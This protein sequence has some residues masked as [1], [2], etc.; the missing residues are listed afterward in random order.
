MSHTDSPNATPRFVSLARIWDRS[1]H[2]AFT[3]LLRHDAKWWCTFCE[4]DNHGSSIGTVRII[5][6]DDGESWTSIAEL[7]EADIDLRDPK[8]SVTPDGRMVLLTCGCTRGEATTRS[9][10]V[11]F[12][13]DGRNW[14]TP[15][16]VLT[17]D[18][19]LWR[20]T[21]HGK[22]GY[23]VPKLGEG[24][25]PRRGFLYRTTKGI[26]WQWITE[27]IFP[28]NIWTVSV[29]MLRIMPDEQMIALIRPNLIGSSDPPYTKWTFTPL[30]HL[31]GG[32][33]F[34]RLPD[35]ALW[36]MS[37]GKDSHGRPRTVLA[38]MSRNSYESV[39]EL[40]SGGDS[41]Y[42]GMVWHDETLWISITCHTKIRTSIYLAK[43]KF[44]A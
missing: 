34:I 6:S 35:D 36:A 14:S 25:N 32:P 15:A 10:W 24:R 11:A 28:G 19:W 7:T 30:D 41:S 4:A 27:F 8:L 31:L 16:R 3:D 37:R 40:P 38:C 44:D 21:W 20:V 13:D 39:L 12:S 26:D 22:V 18:H 29:T 17:E 1:P 33:N 9:P 23:S 5:V 42:A 43:L 2:N